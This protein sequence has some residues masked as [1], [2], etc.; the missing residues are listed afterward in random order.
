[1]KYYKHMNIYIRS[2]IFNIFLPLWTI[3]ISVLL[4]PLVI[5]NNPKIMSLLGISW[6][7][8]TILALRV[9]C[10]IK[11]EVIGSY[12]LPTSPYIIACKHQS[13]IETAFF[14]QY[15]RF[16]VYV[17]KKELLQI[18]FYGWFL[19]RMG[20]IVIDRKGGISS[21]KKMLR[22]CAKNLE[23][24]R[25]IIIFP[26]GTRV[27]PYKSVQYHSGII[28]IKKKFLQTPIVPIALNSGLF[29]PKNSWLKYP[30]TM[31]MKILPVLDK[32]INNKDIL[33]QLQHI[34]DSNS[35]DL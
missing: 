1:M 22:D 26:E 33:S 28:A 17:M 4:S 16:P 7:Y 19:Q 6:S 3:F 14:Q 15:L 27:K 29:W 32:E 20:M 5:C 30:G 9:I 13:I 2:L 12:N 21:L 18:P 31:K 25:S 8:V 11:I 23:H 10:N 24:N 35:N 34:I